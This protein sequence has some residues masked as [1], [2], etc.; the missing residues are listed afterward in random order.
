MEEISQTPK[1]RRFAEP[2]FISEIKTPDVE[3]PRRAKSVLH[4][5][6]QIDAT[7]SKKIKMLQDK[8]R[9]LRN[10]IGSL[11]QLVSHLRDNG[12]MTEEAGNV[13][14]VHISNAL[15]SL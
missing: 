3:T 2:R 8:T 12:L 14:T 11:Q 1:R 7:K 6:R 13:L 15:K 9:Y 4:L 5:V 10:R